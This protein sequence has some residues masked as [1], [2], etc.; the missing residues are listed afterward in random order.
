MENRI[1]L[2]TR[3]SALALWQAE[4]AREL[5]RAAFPD[6]EVELVVIKTTADK[7]PQAPIAKLGDK[8][9]FVKEIEDALLE[10]RADAGVHSLK[11]LPAVLPDG[12]ELAAVLER[13]DPRDALVTR[14]PSSIKELPKGA[15]VATSSLRR[16]GQMLHLRPDVKIVPVRGNVDTRIRKIREH[17]F[18]ALLLA[19]AGVERLGLGK[20]VVVSPLPIE[21]FVPAAAQGAIGLEAPASSEFYELFKKLNQPAVALSVESE[22]HVIRLLGA[23]CRTPIGCHFAMKE[24]YAE[25][26]VTIAPPKCVPFKFVRRIEPSDIPKSLLQA[27]TEMR[28]LCP[29]K[30]L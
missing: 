22:R 10:G 5:I 12:L 30:F 26:W 14:E 19:M 21:D 18:D 8:G 9:V 13:G 20:D 25:L 3:G 23:D 6:I 28:E 27:E 16:A 11:D 1:R 15:R 2:A 24:K 29:A 17:E 4:R 7:N